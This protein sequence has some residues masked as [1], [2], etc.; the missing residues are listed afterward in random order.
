MAQIRGDGG[1]RKMLGD[2]FALK[3]NLQSAI[4]AIS[5]LATSAEDYKLLRDL[6]VCSETALEYKFYVFVCLQAE[7]EQSVRSKRENLT[8]K[9]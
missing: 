6:L 3:M 9:P 5:G 8:T 4:E 2:I 7:I 1:F